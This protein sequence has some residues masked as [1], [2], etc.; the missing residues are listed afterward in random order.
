MS[1]PRADG[2]TPEQVRTV[3]ITRSYLNTSPGAVHIAMGHTRVLCT[4]TAEGRVP[5]FRVGSGGGW[6]TAEYAMLPGSSRQRVPRESATGRPN[7]R[8]REIQRLIGRALRAC[9]DLDRIGERTL[10]VDCDVLQ[11]DGGTR[12]AAI[13]GAYVALA[14]AVCALR[15][16]GLL[17]TDPLLEAA[18]AVSV[19]VVQ[20]RLLVDLCY[21][22]DAAA[23]VDFN[24]VMTRSGGLL[25]VQGTAERR[26]FSRQETEAM[27]DLA[28]RGLQEVFRAQDEALRGLV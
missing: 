14:E 10:Y 12:T 15:R 16:D 28:A 18:A 7:S 6:L 11:A 19:G 4:V 8:S 9:V 22:E 26:P 20:D 27:L 25:E 13:T 21:E 24:V 5:P 23:Q 1:V 2:R 3:A 17:V